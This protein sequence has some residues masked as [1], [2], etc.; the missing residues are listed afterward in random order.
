M[1]EPVYKIGHLLGASW[2]ASTALKWTI[3][4]AL[5]VALALTWALDTIVLKVLAAHINHYA[6]Q[7]YLLPLLFSFVT[8]PLFAGLIMTGVRHARNETVSVLTPFT[9]YCQILRLGITI[10]IVSLI[11]DI[12]WNIAQLSFFNGDSAHTITVTCSVIS[13]IVTLLLLLATPLAA[14][15]KISP[16][17]AIINALRLGKTAFG[18]TLG[19]FL[20]AYVILMICFYFLAF[21]FVATHG[22]V[23]VIAIITILLA[24]WLLPWA[25]MVYAYIYHAIVDHAVL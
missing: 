2:R 19:V 14:D 5:L 20:I 4:P 25:I 8:G 1:K 17:G 24:I 16:L 10:F 21:L 3:W 11:S 6:V 13:L 15:K 18:Q 9:Y 23:V 22:M 12:G 7:Y